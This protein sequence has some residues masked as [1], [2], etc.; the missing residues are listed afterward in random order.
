MY[1]NRIRKQWQPIFDDIFG[2]LVTETNPNDKWTFDFGIV[3]KE[4]QQKTNPHLR[5]LD[6][7]F[8][9]N[10]RCSVINQ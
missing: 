5:F 7:S 3:K 4:E 6:Y 8:G 1:L 9:V 10:Y 2:Q